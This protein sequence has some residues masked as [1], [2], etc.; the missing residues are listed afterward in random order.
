MIELN[1]FKISL[2]LF[3]LDSS[4]VIFSSISLALLI[5]SFGMPAILATLVAKLFS[6]TPFINLYSKITLSNS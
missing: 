6:A 4:F 2:F 1:F 5:T 3:I